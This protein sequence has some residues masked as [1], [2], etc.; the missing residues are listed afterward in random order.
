M[1]PAS[2]GFHCPE[3][4]AGGGQR[5]I[6]TKTLGQPKMGYILAGAI[7]VAYIAQVITSKSLDS[8]WAVD[9][10]AVSRPAVAQG[11]W[12]RL[13]TSGFVHLGL[14]HLAFNAY[15]LYV[16]GSILE[17]RVGAWGTAAVFMGGVVGGSA[18]VVIT[19]SAAAGASGG[20]YALMGAMVIDLLLQRRPVFS[21]A[22]GRLLGMNLLLSVVLIRSVSL[23]GHIGGLIGGC[24]VGAVLLAS[25]RAPLFNQ[26]GSSLRPPLL[27]ATARLAVAWGLVVLMV[28][29]GA[30][31][32]NLTYGFT[33]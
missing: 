1:N 29:F 27:S 24:L 30:L 26:S 14:I 17:R 15:F 12:W 32:A 20:A 19:N 33:N 31:M 28:G 25:P 8:G 13:I 21:S 2:V 6:T 4:V 18:A 5:V 16:M 10:F 7:V 3:C 23:A 11:E 22:V 9:Q